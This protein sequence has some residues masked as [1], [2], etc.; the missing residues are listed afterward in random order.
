MELGPTCGAET[1]RDPNREITAEP[2]I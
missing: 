1:V 2:F